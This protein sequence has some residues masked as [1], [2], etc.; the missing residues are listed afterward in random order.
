MEAQKIQTQLQTKWLGK[1]IHIRGEVTSTN[2]WALESLDQG[3]KRGEVFLADYQTKGRGRLER[4][5]ESPAGKNILL[6]FVD[7]LPE[8]QI[9]T[10]QLALVAGVGFWDGLSHSFPSLSF[11]LK[12][13]NDIL[14]NE[15]KLGGLLCERH[16]SLP[17]AVI[18]VGI[19]VN[20]TKEEFT[21]E[22]RQTAISLFSV[23]GRETN[24][25]E[26]VASCLNSYEKWRDI[27]QDNGLSQIIEAWQ[28]HSILTRRKIRV[29]EMSE[30]YEGIAQGIDEDGFLIVNAEGKERKVVTGDII[31]I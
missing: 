22:I 26:L 4:Q 31:L 2:S 27:Y 12:W 21:P 16:R 14:L 13:P 7:D 20:M 8:D 9:K 15:L 28:K 19:N 11:K 23:L 18:G 25:D 6:S 1:K 29:V 30:T 17:K 3:A 24:R 10:P 5:W